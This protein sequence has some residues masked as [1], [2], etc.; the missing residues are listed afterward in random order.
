MAD[1][2]YQA[3]ARKYRPQSFDDVV[4]QKHVI[5]A[6]RNTIDANRL[7]H[8]YLLTGTRGI[9]KTT[10][11]RIIAKCLQCPNGISSHPHKDGEFC[12]VCDA[13]AKGSF[14]DVIEIDAASQTKVDDTRQL[15]ENTR[16]PP[17]SGRFKIYIIDEVHMLS[18][19][20]FNALLKTLEEPPSYVKFILATTDP[21]KIPVTVLSRCLQFQ[22]KALS[23]DEIK[24]QILKICNQEGILCEDAGAS[25][26]AR[27]ARGSMRD[28]L[29]LCDQAIAL[30]N[31][32]IKRDGVVDMLGTAGDGIIV[33]ILNLLSSNGEPDLGALLEEIRKISPNYKNLMDEIV[34]CFHDLSLYQI[35]GKRSYNLFSLSDE[36]LDL[37]APLF[38]PETLQTYYQ[39]ALQGLEENNVTEGASAFEMMVLRLLA[40]T[41]EKKKLG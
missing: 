4:G 1:S 35:L 32:S 41:P 33:N 18:I 3:L 6:L 10:I 31:G 29:S 2:Q 23:Q 28:A 39:I 27:A 17:L 19:S 20:S 21:H 7:H 16:Y 14:P 22:L 12:E 11:A 36:L 9:G 15:L 26:I 25:L 34:T 5:T 37:Y 40:F 13:I 38:A 24:G 30:G 8:A